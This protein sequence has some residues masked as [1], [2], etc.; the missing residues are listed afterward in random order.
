MS[1]TADG[2][3]DDAEMLCGELFGSQA[4]LVHDAGVDNPG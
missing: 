1:V 4:V 2:E 3:I